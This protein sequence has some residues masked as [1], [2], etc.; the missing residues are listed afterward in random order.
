MDKTVPV[1][2]TLLFAW[3][4]KKPG[5]AWNSI[6]SQKAGTAWRLRRRET[7]KTADDGRADY[8]VPVL[9][10]LAGAGAKVA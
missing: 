10:D 4:L 8:I 3:A 5:S 7:D 2:N 6:F 1:E 9:P